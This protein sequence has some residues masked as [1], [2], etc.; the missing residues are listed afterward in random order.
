MERSIFVGFIIPERAGSVPLVVRFIPSV[1]RSVGQR[2]L[3]HVD[4]LRRF[5]HGS[6]WKI[7]LTKRS[8]GFIVETKMFNWFDCFIG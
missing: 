1:A 7:A 2:T 8:I 4:W 3:F 6:G 5:V